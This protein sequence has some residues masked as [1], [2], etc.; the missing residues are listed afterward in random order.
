MS[1]SRKIKFNILDLSI[2]LV[3]LVV[4]C[5]FLLKGAMAG[6]FD[7]LQNCDVV[8]SFTVE[9]SEAIKA[10]V[11]DEILY[12]DE[13]VLG[14]LEAVEHSEKDGVYS[15]LCTFSSSAK[16]SDGGYVFADQLKLK[17]GNLIHI[18]VGGEPY[19]VAILDIKLK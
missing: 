16:I 18:T 3:L 1:E 5:S 10:A 13:I 6:F 12:A 11:G 4:L 7:G 19:S 15:A 14:R 9:D 8:V 17:S 2:L